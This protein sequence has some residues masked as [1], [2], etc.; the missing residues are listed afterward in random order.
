MT[1]PTPT[2]KRRPPAK[3]G[4]TGKILLTALSLS[5]FVGGWAVLAR[6]EGLAE[7][8]EPEVPP[9]PEPMPIALQPT[10]TPWPTIRPLDTLPPIPT[11][12]PLQLGTVAPVNA[13]SQSTI[14]A[15]DLT[16]PTLAPPPTLVPSPTSPPPP[17]ATAPPTAS[18]VVDNAAPAAPT[19]Q[20]TLLGPVAGVTHGN[21]TFQWAWSEPVPAGYGFEVV[22]WHPT[23]VPL[24]AHDAVADNQNGRVMALGNGRYAAQLDISYAAGVQ[25]RPGDYVW[26]V[27]L[28]QIQPNYAGTGIQS[29]PAPLRY[30]AGGGGGGGNY[31]GGQKTKGS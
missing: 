6:Q 5:S 9:T 22:V 24:G 29:Q 13:R 14:A 15:L 10:L 25:G 28:V 31:G 19:G 2:K 12:A 8:Q 20:L 23:G 27:Q 26:A 17:T 4:A 11:V 21:T 1:K 3:L 30:E 16:L 18:P 7:A